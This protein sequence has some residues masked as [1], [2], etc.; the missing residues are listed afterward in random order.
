MEIGNLLTGL[1][2]TGFLALTGL[3]REGR[4]II[5]GTAPAATPEATL[6][7]VATGGTRLGRKFG[8]GLL[9][10]GSFEPG[11]FV[12]FTSTAAGCE[13]A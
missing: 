10:P 13:V 1:R 2:R 9:G 11:L 12:A 7:A 8:G 4:V 6:G 5:G 3:I